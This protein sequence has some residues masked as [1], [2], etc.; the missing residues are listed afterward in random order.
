MV[1]WLAESGCERWVL[2]LIPANSKLF[3]I[4]SKIICHWC[5][6]VIEFKKAQPGSQN[7]EA[8]LKVQSHTWAWY[9]ETLQAS[10]SLTKSRLFA[11]LSSL[12]SRMA[13]LVNRV[14]F[15]HSSSDTLLPSPDIFWGSTTHWWT[16]VPRKKLLCPI[17]RI[18]WGLEVH[19]I[20]RI[21]A[22]FLNKLMIISNLF[23]LTFK[24][25]PVLV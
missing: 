20:A 13:W 23:C 25:E 18:Y 17:F 5:F 6:L 14:H 21:I 12:Q 24:S 1:W 11:I 2:G 7:E 22:L 10:F 19:R 8:S 4:R 15:L 3:F 9:S 16:N